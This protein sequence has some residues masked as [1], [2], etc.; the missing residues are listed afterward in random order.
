MP[1]PYPIAGRAITGHAPAA[2]G[3]E[4]DM[5][6]ATFNILSGRSPDDPHVDEG[7]YRAAI[8]AL[9]ADLLGLQEVDRNQPRSQHADLTAI[10]ADEMGAPHHLFVAALA[11]TPGATWSAATGDEQPDSAAYGVAF[12]SR[13]D[14]LGWRVVRLP[15]A[16]LPVPHRFHGRR[17]PTWVRD[18]PRVAVVAE[19]DAPGGRLDV[20]TTH[21]SF[22]RPWNGRQLRHLMASLAPRKQPLVLLGDLNMTPAP[23]G[24]I[25]GLT[26]LASAATFPASDPREQIDHILGDRIPTPVSARAVELPMS[27][28]R[29]L[30]VDL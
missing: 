3:Y 4:E 30:V 6:I 20:A 25:T 27:D 17:L 28:H 21:L 9:D 2:P 12:L 5:R 14:V 13:H 15:G 1:A 16:P 29:A 26:A 22:L 18:E 19:V 11:G 8:R 23:A 24:R 7:R 10:A